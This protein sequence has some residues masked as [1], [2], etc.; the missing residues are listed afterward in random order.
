VI[1]HVWW[2]LLLAHEHGPAHAAGAHGAS[3]TGLLLLPHHL[4]LLLALLHH[5]VLHVAR[6]TDHATVGTWSQKSH[7]RTILK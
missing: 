7:F 4:L 6:A 2:G 1:L 5:L 3:H